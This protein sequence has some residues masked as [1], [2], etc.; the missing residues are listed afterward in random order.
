MNTN[1]TLPRTCGRSFSRL[2]L[3]VHVPSDDL[4]NGGVLPHQYSALVTQRDPDLLRAYIV[5]SYHEHLGVLI[6]ELLHE[7]RERLRD[8]YELSLPLV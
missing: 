6:Q 2:G 1:P 5:S 7:K 8:G 3:A 4:P